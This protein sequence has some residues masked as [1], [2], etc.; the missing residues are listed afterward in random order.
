[1][2]PWNACADGIKCLYKESGRGGFILIRDRVVF[3]LHLILQIPSIH[4]EVWHGKEMATITCYSQTNFQGYS[5]VYSTDQPDLTQ[6]FPNGIHSARVVTNPV[7]VFQ[8]TNYQTPS[9]TLA[10]GEYPD[11]TQFPPGEAGFMSLRVE[12]I[13]L[14]IYLQLTELYE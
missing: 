8:G 2:N 6:D 11:Q 13:E 1:M 9:A 7:T 3:A 10:V 4:R 12:W 5:Q 14:G